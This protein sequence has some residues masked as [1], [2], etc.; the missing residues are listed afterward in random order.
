MKILNILI[1]IIA[2]LYV[3]AQERQLDR[4]FASP[5]GT[6]KTGVY[7]YWM[8]GN[9]SKEGVVKDLEAMKKA[10][11]NR[12]FIGNNYFDPYEG[13]RNV[14]LM[15]EEW[16]DITHTALKTASELGIEIGIFNSPG[17]TTAGGPWVKSDQTMRYL[18]S[19]ETRVKGPGRV[20][21]LLKKPI[22]P[23]QDV[24]VIAYPAHKEDLLVLNHSNSKIEI[25]PFLQNQEKMFDSY[26]VEGASLPRDT[27]V[28]VSIT[29]YE[30][31]T[32]RSLT[33]YPTHSHINASFELQ[34][35]AGNNFKTISQFNIHWYKLDVEN[36]FLP[37]AP[38]VISFEETTAKE[39][40]ILMKND[41]HTGGIAEIELS[42]S[43]LIE[44]Y[45][46]KTMA[47]MYQGPMPPW[48][49]YMWRG[50]PEVADLTLNIAPEQVLDISQ[51]MTPDGNLT[52]NAPE[53]E[54]VILR[55]GMT[56]T[57]RMN[58]P[59]G[60]DGTGL[61]IDKMNKE[62]LSAHFDAFIGKILEKIPAEDRKTFKIVVQDSY[63]AGSQNFTDDFL[64][65]FK[66]RYGYDALPFLPAYF[67]RVVGS[68][69]QSDRFLWDLRRLIADRIAYDYVGGFREICH[70]NGLRT[71]LE[72]YGHWG[73][74]SEFLMYGGQ[75]DEVAG[76]YWLPNVFP[77]WENELGSIENRAA[78][79]CAHIYG[80]KIV[81]SESNTSGGPAFSRV[82]ADAKQRTDKYFAE[83]INSTLLHVYIQQPDSDKY[84][85]T[86]AWF[87]T[88]FNRMN[89]WFS[90]ADLFIDYTKRCNYMLQQGIN[91]ADIAYFI[92]EDAPKMT[93][94]QDPKLPAGYQFD[95]IN[96]EVIVRDATVKNG[97][98]TLPHG[99]TYRV[100]VL[101]KLLT[102]RPE[103]L[104]KIK[105][106]VFDGAVVLGPA[107]VCSPS[108]Q[109]QPEADSLVKKMAVEL[110]GKVDGKKITS[111]KVGKGMIFNVLSLEEVFSK[112]GCIPDCKVSD[113]APINFGHRQMDK[114]D[115]YFI[116]NQDENVQKATLTFRSKGM[117]PELFDPVTGTTRKLHEF[118]FNGETTTVPVSLQRYESAF[119]VFREKGNPVPG[120]ENFPV[121]TTVIALKS[122]WDVSFNGKLTNPASIRLDQL[123]DLSKSDVDLIRYFSGSIIYTTSFDLD[124]EDIK[125]ENIYL[126]LGEVNK[127]AKV[128]VN[129]QYVGGVWT[130]PYS[131]N[132]S[133]ALKKGT[134][135]LRIDVVNTWVNRMIGDQT[136]PKKKRETWAGENPYKPA[137]PLQKSGLLGPVVL[138]YVP[139]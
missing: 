137:S 78:S 37:F 133:S 41:L 7:W 71:W 47:K 27:E 72:N 31:F 54:W 89:T 106:L 45:A 123:Q 65:L 81:T 90:H 44:N 121:P 101:P 59:G 111:A 118:S 119:I 114:T 109:D 42:A 46:A 84:P 117:Q 77:S 43:P 20:S 13:G 120:S 16:W 70:R 83:G 99:T 53:G 124:P 9:I 127:M 85:G 96:A 94:I 130:P 138:K 11:I 125:K 131:L 128:W 29:A 5:P 129:D 26:K 64:S 69:A 14:K 35:K 92:G 107:P 97:L 104:T 100:L 28:V 98:I 19:S 1:L 87:G 108:L 82:P 33:I 91:V 74:P 76:E 24:K 136:L 4:E 86:N 79:S 36:G 21:L 49:Y 38:T 61:E 32:A 17:W 12:A 23:F 73:F 115:I 105:Q 39:F 112:I 3:G 113:N 93:G 132:I 2:C 58:F 8:C 95:Y 60:P 68:K 30:P 15:S 52:W 67:G 63:E 18:T 66:E 25:S 57:G 122:A 110:W 126:D 135:K 116:T 75:S 48:D 134:N 88:E 80:K 62:H 34:A 40:R 102:M 103:V 10:G 50:Q 6:V 55:T 51:Y 22:D 139:N 56:P